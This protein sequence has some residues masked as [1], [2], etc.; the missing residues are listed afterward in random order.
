[1]TYTLVWT[2]RFRRSADRFHRALPEPRGRFA[3]VLRELEQDPLQPHLRLHALH[4]R[5]QGMHAVSIS[6]SHRITLTLRLSEGEIVL[7]DVGS[8]DE[9]YR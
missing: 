9:V 3:R 2:S 4:G 5:L 8:H 7:L 1:M 6:H